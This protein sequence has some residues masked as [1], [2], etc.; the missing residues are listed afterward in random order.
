LNSS[1]LS[2]LFLSFTTTITLP[3]HHNF[4]PSNVRAICGQQ[5]DKT[6]QVKHKMDRMNKKQKMELEQ[7]RKEQK[8]VNEELYPLLTLQRE[9]E[10]L[11][12]SKQLL[13]RMKNEAEKEVKKEQQL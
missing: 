11:E 6:K 1:T 12:S 3:P 8:L 13:Q 7:V 5:L 4:T 9:K 10:E 2:S